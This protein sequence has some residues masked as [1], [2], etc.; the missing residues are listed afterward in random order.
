MDDR[1]LIQAKNQARYATRGLL[2]ARYFG[3]LSMLPLIWLLRHSDVAALLI[4]IFLVG[5]CTMIATGALTRQM[6][7]AA[8][9]EV[10]YRQT[11]GRNTAANHGV[12]RTGVPPTARP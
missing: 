5:F 1:A 12:E 9:S 8:E 6:L 4:S 11:I 10:E 3:A 7:I 2:L